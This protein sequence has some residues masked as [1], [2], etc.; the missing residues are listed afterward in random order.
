[1]G[2]SEVGE[3]SGSIER[4]RVDAHLLGDRGIERAL[5][6]F[7]RRTRASGEGQH[8]RLANSGTGDVAQHDR[9]VERMTPV[10]CEIG[11]A[12]VAPAAPAGRHEDDRAT[13]LALRE[14]TC[15]LEQSS[16][17]RQLRLAVAVRDGVTVGED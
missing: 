6:A 8:E 12:R 10:K 5:Q 1:E 17:T 9:C 15:E 7:G 3:L 11:G 2:K 4:T 13:R 14:D 16:R